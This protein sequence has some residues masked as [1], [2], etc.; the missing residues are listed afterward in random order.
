M[1]HYKNSNSFKPEQEILS[2]NYNK[3]NAK[4]KKI[5]EGFK[6]KLNLLLE[7][8]DEK[9]ENS[10]KKEEFSLRNVNEKIKKENEDLSAELE[11]YLFQLKEISGSLGFEE[12]E[13]NYTYGNIEFLLKQIKEYKD[14]YSKSVENASEQFN[15]RVNNGNKEFLILCG[16][17]A[18][19]KK[20]NELLKKEKSLLLELYENIKAIFEK[21]K[22]LEEQLEEFADGS[23]ADEFYMAGSDEYEDEKSKKAYS[24][25]KAKYLYEKMMKTKS[26]GVRL[27]KQQMFKTYYEILRCYIENYKE[28]KNKEDEILLEMLKENK[29]DVKLYDFQNTYNNLEKRDDK[30]N[31]DF[32]CAIR[33]IERI[34][35]GIDEKAKKFFDYDLAENFLKEFYE[36]FEIDR[37][38]SLIKAF[39]EDYEK[40]KNSIDE[41]IHN[42]KQSHIKDEKGFL[43]RFEQCVNFKQNIKEKLFALKT[44]LDELPKKII[45]SNEFLLSYNFNTFKNKKN[46]LKK[47]NDLKQQ[48]LEK[49]KEETEKTIYKNSYEEVEKTLKNVYE[50]YKKD[51][52]NII[53]IN[54]KTKIKLKKL[55]YDENSKEFKEVINI[56][57]RKMEEEKQEQQQKEKKA[58]RLKIVEELKI[59]KNKFKEKIK[60]ICIL[61]KEIKEIVKELN[62]N[63]NFNETNDGESLDI[64]K[65]EKEMIIAFNN[66][67]SYRKN[68]LKKFE[69]LSNPTVKMNE[70]EFNRKSSKI[71]KELN[72][73]VEVLEEYSESLNTLKGNIKVVKTLID[74]KQ[75][76]LHDGMN[77]YDLAKIFDYVNNRQ[78]LIKKIIFKTY[79][80]N[81]FLFENAEKTPLNQIL[82]KIENKKTEEKKEEELNVKRFNSYK[83]F[84]PKIIDSCYEEFMEIRDFLTIT[85]EG[86]EEESK[87][88]DYKCEVSLILGDYENLDYYIFKNSR[89]NLN[90]AKK[91]FKNLTN[92]LAELKKLN[93]FIDGVTT[94][95]IENKKHEISQQFFQN[96]K[97]CKKIYS[98]IKKEVDLNGK[99]EKIKKQINL[100]KNLDKKQKI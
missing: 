30:L 84:Y 87:L 3:K 53:S 40:V 5:P 74:D 42:L 47:G 86:E 13:E 71:L 36:K 29:L 38:I 61:R 56:N 35:N 78:R 45:V 65:V 91:V 6:N 20:L 62:S 66:Y 7:F 49:E 43:K 96:L 68:L 17:I 22:L 31:N 34:L 80:R 23:Q 64:E 90:L 58:N 77:D 94:E 98:E 75:K 93:K 83:K 12:V 59:L 14:K 79:E 55:N 2:N 82:K 54:M 85:F 48:K 57:K 10:F 1:E 92:I 44:K 73:V 41:E 69:E 24:S 76:L 39:V 25:K 8:L 33:E 50:Q 97:T 19:E 52:S 18:I 28:G 16:K 4:N 51:F 89:M 46:N 21:H 70:E 67:E 100:Q 99:K 15:R 88:I 32:R 11:I 9:K 27:A 60:K 37:I 81:I 26:E 95:D 63:F 72:N